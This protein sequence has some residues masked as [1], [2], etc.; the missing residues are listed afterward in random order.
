MRLTEE[1]MGWGIGG[2]RIG[3]TL[4][5]QLTGRARGLTGSA[6]AD[7]GAAVKGSADTSN[8]QPDSAPSPGNFSGRPLQT[9]GTHFGRHCCRLVF[10]TQARLDLVWSFV[11]ELR[12]L[13]LARKC[14]ACRMYIKASS[15][16][17]PH[18]GASPAK[19]AEQF[20]YAGAAWFMYAS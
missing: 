7:K 2:G 15:D 9:R 10:G 16:A 20:A 12:L 14:I 18:T 6:A 19:A 17:T 3:G 13:V 8:C 1:R 5:I 4:D 11:L